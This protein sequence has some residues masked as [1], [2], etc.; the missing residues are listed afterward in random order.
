[1]PAQEQVLGVEERRGELRPEREEQ[2]AD[3][4]RRDHGERGEQE[5]APHDR[6]HARP[7]RCQARAPAAPFDRLGHPQR[8]RERDR[9][10]DQQQHVRQHARRR[11][12]LDDRSAHQYA[13]PHARGAH[14]TVGQPDPR[15]IAPRVQVEQR[16][17]C[18]AEREPRGQPLH[19]ARG[20]QPRDGVGDHEEE[21]RGHQRSQRDEQHR[22]PP[23]LVRHAA[24]EQERGEHAE[25]VGRV[26]EREHRRREAPQLAIRRVERRR[27]AGREQRQADHGRHERVRGRRGERAPRGQ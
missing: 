7:L 2:A 11:Q 22:P 6:R 4:P 20:E 14:D 9:E 18:G 10:E 16:G 15:R 24:G 26:D 21:R 27:R 8:A 23:D 12:Q 1:M 5:R 25:R 17:T 13:Q 3:R 19:A